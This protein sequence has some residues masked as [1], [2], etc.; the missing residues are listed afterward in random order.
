MSK[1]QPTAKSLQFSLTA[2]NGKQYDVAVFAHQIF[3]K[4][5][6]LRTTYKQEGSSEWSF[7][8][9]PSIYEA[10]VVTLS[11]LREKIRLAVEL[12]NSR[13]T[14]FFLLDSEAPPIPD[15]A[16]LI[17]RIESVIVSSLQ[18]DGDKIIIKEDEE[19]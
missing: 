14:E 2:G 18:W 8:A 1:N 10:E 13:L 15:T 12:I 3:D 9:E 19:N 16:T 4:E 7:I 6:G 11:E 17:S 5:V